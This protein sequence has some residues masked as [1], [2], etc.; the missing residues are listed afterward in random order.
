M[1]NIQPKAGSILEDF[2]SMNKWYV[3][4]DRRYNFSS[5]GQIVT[6]MSSADQ[7]RRLSELNSPFGKEIDEGLTLK[8]RLLNMID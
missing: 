4:L 6:A 2:S 1:Q 5:L 8:G 3:Q 7:L